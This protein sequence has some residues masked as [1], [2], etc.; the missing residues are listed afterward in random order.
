MKKDKIIYWISTGLFSLVMAF[1]GFKYFTD[2]HI[3][4][5]MRHL[6]FPDYFRVELGIA[7]L[8]GVVAL[9]VPM[10]PKAVKG[11]TYSGF[12]IV[13]VSAA[14]AHGCSGDPVGNVIGPFIFLTVLGI[15][16]LYYKKLNHAK[17]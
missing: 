6:G 11:F 8:L 1:S 5:A 16:Y 14:I 7:K 12:A 3:L 4:E 17:E 2:E 13:C 10:V 9:L 15:S